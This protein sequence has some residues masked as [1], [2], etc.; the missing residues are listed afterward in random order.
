MII[1]TKYLG[2]MD[3]DE[4]DIINFPKGLPGFEDRKEFVLLGLEGNEHFTVLQDISEQ[5]ISFLLVNPWDFYKDYEFEIKN[6][7]IKGI[8]LESGDKS[9]VN[10]YN[11]ITLGK[12]L[13]E[14]TCNLLA[15]I[16][17]NRDGKKGRQVILNDFPYTTK[18]KLF[19]EGEEKC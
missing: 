1:K 5:Y 13:D 2:D 18:H 19:S 6:E 11:I 10:V 12:T 16:I 8:E 9:S 15:P 17:I 7:V 3:I 4:N 14:S